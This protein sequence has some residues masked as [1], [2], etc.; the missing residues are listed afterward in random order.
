MNLSKY[1]TLKKIIAELRLVSRKIGSD[2]RI[3]KGELVAMVGRNLL[4]MA[5][6]LNGAQDPYYMETANVNDIGSAMG[7]TVVSSATFTNSTKTVT[8]AAHTLQNSDIGKRILLIGN[9]RYVITQITQ[10]VD[11]NNFRVL[12][13][14][15]ENIAALTYVLYPF[16]YA[17]YVSLSGLNV[18]S[19][20]KLV[21]SN[22]GEISPAGDSDIE[23]ITDLDDVSESVFYNH[24][25]HNLELKLGSN[26]TGLGTLTLYYYRIPNLPVDMTDY[27]DL[28]DSL[29]PTLIN[30][31][32]LEIYELAGITAP[33]NLASAVDDKIAALREAAGSR[34]EKI[35][36][37]QG[38]K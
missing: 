1:Y 31:C 23:N 17:N 12:H 24:V 38:I 5:A 11:I 32:K 3:F 8:K 9:G 10:I 37:S 13:E 30:K 14:M 27:I 26:V 6:I 19:I 36:H 2:S 25:G 21:C 22:N 33:Q 34:E 35:I 16:H 4:D 18:D 7:T 29:I 28:K 15:G 20:I